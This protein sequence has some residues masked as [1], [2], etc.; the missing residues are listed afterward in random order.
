MAEP[1]ASARSLPP[2]TLLYGDDHQALHDRMLALMASMDDTAMADLN[3]T[4]LDGAAQNTSVEDVRNAAF[5]LPFLSPRRMVILTN[6]DHLMK[7]EA[8]G[9]K[10]IEMLDGLPETTVLLLVQ[11]DSWIA[12]GKQ[13]GWKVMYEYREKN[14]LK[15]HP[16]LD[17]ARKAAPKARIEVHRLPAL[18]AM[19]GWISAEAKRQGGQITPKAAV[20]MAAIIGNDTGQVRQEI[21]KL[22]AYLDYS[23]PI[24]PETVHQLT[25]PGGQADVFTMVDA[26]ATGDARQ[27]TRQLTRLLAEQDAAGLFGMV[28][29]Q[30]RLILMAK[31][32]TARGITGEEELARMLGVPAYPATKALSQAR[33]YSPQSL[34][35]IYHRLLE[36]DKM[37]KTG[38]V[39]LEVAL[40]AFVAEMGR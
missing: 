35:R 8:A 2:V 14:K 21:A 16:L 28:V 9:S 20:E 30:Y 19:P 13:R 36:I 6:P 25:A 33:L 29:R 23:R 31:E 27:A 4:R 38:Q 34:N 10:L 37:S 18:N 12:S 32:A 39:E 15:I 17:W 22:L 26:L 3:I 7:S 5:T 1:T 11:D 24:E 40:Q